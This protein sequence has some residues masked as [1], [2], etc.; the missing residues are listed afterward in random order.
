MSFQPVVPLA[1]YGGWTF[2]QRSLP[3][4]QAAFRESPAVQRETAY[5]RDQIPQV[6][7]AEDLVEDRRLLGVALGAYGLGDDIDNRFFLQRILADGTRDPEALSNKLSDK[8]YRSLSAAFGL[9]PGDVSLTQVSRFADD[10]VARYEAEQ[11]A[12]RV[13]EVAPDLRLALNVQPALD[14]IMSETRTDTGRWFTIL[15][16]APLRQVFERA[17]GLPAGIGRIDLDQQL[18]VFQDRAQRLFDAADPAD[19]T[20]PETQ[21]KLIRLFLV[22]SEAAAAA[23]SAGASVALTLLQAAPVN[24]AP[25]ILP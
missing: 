6:N 22:R 9:G 2:L 11:F 19:F 21:E 1:G 25:P 13:G 23:N 16:N 8:R 3:A 7:G 18:A 14:D 4:Q 20:R 17:F 24:L 12:I 10:I 5:F 15:G